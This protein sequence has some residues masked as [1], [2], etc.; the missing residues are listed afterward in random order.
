MHRSFNYKVFRKRSY[1]V[2]GD[3][4]KKRGSLKIERRKEKKK[5]MVEDHWKLEV[6]AILLYWNESWKVP[7]I[8][9]CPASSQDKKS[10]P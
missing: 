4:G 3:G 8:V 2:W 10:V 5:D 7:C 1:V 9:H 6:G